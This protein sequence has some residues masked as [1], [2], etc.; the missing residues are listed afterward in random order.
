[1]KRLALDRKNPSFSE[2]GRSGTGG[3]WWST[4]GDD[5]K[6]KELLPTATFVEN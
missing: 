3:H 5:W 2:P 6:F 4:S 1:M